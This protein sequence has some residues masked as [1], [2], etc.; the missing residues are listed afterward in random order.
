MFYKER[1]FPTSRPYS[2]TGIKEN[3]CLFH[4]FHLRETKTFVAGGSDL[5]GQVDE[6]SG[7]FIGCYISLAFF[8]YIFYKF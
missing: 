2:L 8:Y 5:A 1:A 4:H 6:L 7:V 3:G